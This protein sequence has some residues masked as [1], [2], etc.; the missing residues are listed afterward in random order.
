M[1]SVG[2]SLS[3]SREGSRRAASRP[4]PAAPAGVDLAA[5]AEHAAVEPAQ[6]AIAQP[7]VGGEALD[8]GAQARARALQPAGDGRL[9]HGEQRREVGLRQR[10]PVLQ[11]DQ[12]LVVE[13]QAAQR[14]GD[15]PDHL[16]VGEQ[17]GQRGLAGVGKQAVLGRLEPPSP[18][19][20]RDQHEPGDAEQERLE[21]ALAAERVAPAAQHLEGLLRQIL[22]GLRRDLGVEEAEHRAVMALDQRRTG[23]A[24]ARAPGVEQ[25]VVLHAHQDSEPRRPCEAADRI[26][27]AEKG[28]PLWALQHLARHK[29]ESTALQA[30]QPVPA[31]VDGP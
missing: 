22:A 18:P 25:L 28:L 6:A 30:G 7:G 9:G 16:F 19:R 8:G 13:R 3:G 4:R 24:P 10:L 12:D 14:R 2:A 23:L 26:H 17:P 29:H 1:G 15:D 27:L 31:I 11:F 20:P 5:D 21:A